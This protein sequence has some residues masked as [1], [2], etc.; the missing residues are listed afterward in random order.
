M[1]KRQQE[2]LN[3]I[4]QD[5]KNEDHCDDHLPMKVGQAQSYLIHLI[6]VLS[7]E[8]TSDNKTD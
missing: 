8:D 2:A 7:S 6:E 4:Q 1:T 5:L 3:R